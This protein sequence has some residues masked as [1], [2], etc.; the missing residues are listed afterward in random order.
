MKLYT[1]TG[2]DGTTGLYK[3][4]RVYKDDPRVAAY[5]EV[6]ET[7][8]AIGVVLASGGASTLASRL[9]E[10]QSDLFVVGAELASREPGPSV[11][12]I[13]KE[14]IS[15]L[16][17]WIDDACDG[18]PPLRNFIL[19]GGTPGASALHLARAVCRR[20]ERSVITVQRSEPINPLV[21]HYLNRL[22]DL[23]FAWARLVNHMNSQ[24]DIPWVPKHD[25]K[26]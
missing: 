18:L 22:G 20:A 24:P 16:E 23:L 12:Q 7:N 26:A 8:A 9:L 25:R 5:G 11:P 21:V 2:D 4:D 17:G 14:H 19:P 3:G 6:D 13:G 10:I 15:R 1:R